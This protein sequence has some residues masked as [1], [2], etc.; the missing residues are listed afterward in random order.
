MLRL[1]DGL[2]F[3]GDRGGLALRQVPPVREAGDQGEDVRRVLQEERAADAPRL[4]VLLQRG[5][6]EIRAVAGGL[7]VVAPEDLAHEVGVVRPVGRDHAV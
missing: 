3:I 7:D 2:F 6:R 4:N 5:G 1:E